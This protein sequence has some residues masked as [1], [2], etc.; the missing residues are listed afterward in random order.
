MLSLVA[1]LGVGCDRREQIGTYSIPK[2]LPIPSEPVADAGDTITAPKW[3]VPDGWTFIPGQDMR[4]AS[5]SVS[6]DHP[7]VQLTVVP[8]D[9]G[10]G[11]L[12]DNVH[13]WQK[14]LG[15]APSSPEDLK[16]VMTTADLSGTPAGL[17]DMTGTPPT[18]GKPQQRMLAAIVPQPTQT[19][20]F[21]LMGPVD[22]VNAQQSN[23][24]QFIHSLKF[25]TPDQDAAA[26][27][28]AAADQGPPPTDAPPATQP[29]PINYVVPAGWTEKSGQNEF[30]VVAFD[31]PVGNQSGSVI[32]ARMPA[33]SGTILDNIN[34]WRRQVNLDPLTA[35]SQIPAQPLKIGGLDAMMWDIDGPAVAIVAQ[36]PSAGDRGSQPGAAVPQG[37]AVAMV[38]RGSEW[39]FFKLQG[40]ATIVS[41]QK[42]AFLSF[43]QSVQFQGDAP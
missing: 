43:L 37:I 4:F 28:A 35:A 5:F 6:R 33:N 1:G 8:L 42:S 15:L 12:L 23:Y 22:V 25:P 3:T 18:D 26:P 34:R 17:F 11:T 21:K 10:G 19:W 9:A 14:Q 41:A 16:N 29:N 32:V 7:E 27:A 2:T 30:R 31:V 13:R 38:T 36:P 40:P 24:D 20:F 39:W